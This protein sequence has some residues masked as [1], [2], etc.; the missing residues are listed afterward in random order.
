MGWYPGMEGGRAIADI[1]TGTA[2]PGG[3]L[4]V[5]IERSAH[6]LPH[7]DSTASRIAYDA[8]WGQR[9]LDR[10]G[11]VAAFPFGF[12]LGYTTFDMRL[13]SH[14]VGQADGVAE[15]LLVNTG[16]RSGA[17]VAQI[18]AID[19]DAPRP[20]P[21]LIGLERVTLSAGETAAIDIAL[22]LTPT[23][24]R[25]PRSRTWTRRPGQWLIT[26]GAHSPTT[27]DGAAALF[28]RAT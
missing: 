15:V 27:L 1:L 12:G 10:D 4:P 28:E 9:K 25:D 2:E 14:R 20:V 3:R 16:A 23:R 11:N 8:W 5:A 18:Y 17:T 7:F 24:Q 26:V 19:A 13:H 6:H 22:D 21:Q